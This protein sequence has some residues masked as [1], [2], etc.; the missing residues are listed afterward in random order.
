MIFQKLPLLSVLSILFYPATGCSKIASEN[1]TEIED[2]FQRKSQFWISN[3]PNWSA[4]LE[5][6]MR[7][8][9]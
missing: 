4:Y 5:C 3:T 6:I 2:E 9:F 7:A 1:I 8:Y